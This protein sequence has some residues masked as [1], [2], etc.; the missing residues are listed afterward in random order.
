MAELNLTW[1]V[2]V[3]NFNSKQIET[4]NVFNHGGFMD[5]L[6]KAARKFAKD[7]DGFE[8]EVRSSLMY[9]Y[10]CKAEWEVIIQ[11]WPPSERLRDRKVDVFEQVALNWRPFIDYVWAHAVDLRRREPKTE[12]E[13]G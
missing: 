7:R 8:K 6:K 13:E 9:H 2:L 10:W 11:H 1:N 12:K 5:D 4:H 3:G